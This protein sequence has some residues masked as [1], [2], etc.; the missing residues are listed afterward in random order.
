[1][2]GLSE[3]LPPTP[4]VVNVN[5]PHVDLD[6]LRGWRQATVGRIPSRAVK[7]VE[8]V[9]KLGHDG[10]FHVRM[11]WG[12]PVP[13]P[14]ETDGGAVERNEVAVTFLTAIAG[15]GEVDNGPTATALDRLLGR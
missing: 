8:L 5:V 11:I 3:P 9:P 4:V 12:E 7:E 6:K 14:P 2:G 13:L 10:A 1:M 15:D